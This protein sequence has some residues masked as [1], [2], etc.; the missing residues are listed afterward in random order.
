MYYNDKTEKCVI[1]GCRKF[2]WTPEDGWTCM[3]CYPPGQNLLN[4]VKEI[5]N[6]RFDIK[7]SDPKYDT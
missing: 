2:Y 6:N 5:I 1:C 4:Q 7:V 3:R